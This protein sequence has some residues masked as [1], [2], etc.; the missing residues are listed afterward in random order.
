MM[1]LSVPYHPVIMTCETPQ[2]QTVKAPEGAVLSTW[3]P[4]ME[5][6]WCAI[7]MAAGQCGTLEKAQRIFAAEFAPFP[8][9]LE[10]RLFFVHSLE[11]KPLATAALWFGSDLGKP[12]ERIHWVSCVPE[13]EGRGYAKLLMR[14]MLALYHELG[15][16]NGIYLTTQTISY[17]AIGLYKKFGFRPHLD[18][19]PQNGTNWNNT[20]AWQII[21]EKLAAYRKA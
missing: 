13:V 10:R 8:A 7:Q 2:D 4:G 15:S 9:E 12:M 19:M 14:A 20:A 3:K 21:E 18:P 11:G 6:D 16:A 5:Q 1:D 17:P